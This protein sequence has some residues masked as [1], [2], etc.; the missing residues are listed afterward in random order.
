M[1]SRQWK[2]TEQ[3]MSF[4]KGDPTRRS[5]WRSRMRWCICGRRNWNS[6]TL[7]ERASQRRSTP[8]RLWAAS[9]RADTAP[10][11]GR[12]SRTGGTRLLADIRGHP[13]VWALEKSGVSHAIWTPWSPE[14]Q[15]ASTWASSRCIG[16]D[17]E[18]RCECGLPVNQQSLDRSESEV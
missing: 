1:F 18:R 16:W 2:S 9:V 4:A 17:A 5:F 6:K 15:Q 10:E 13:G 12:N 14:S 7:T 11:R 8:R 3:R